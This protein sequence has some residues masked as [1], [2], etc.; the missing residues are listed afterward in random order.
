MRASKQEL[1]PEFVESLGRGLAVLTAFDEHRP[2]LSLSA[3]AEATG[4]ARA[5]ARRALLTLAQLGYV[6]QH[7][8]LFRPTPRVLDLGFARLST[9]TLAQIAQPHLAELVARVHDS[10]SMAVL[11]G[12]DIRYVARVH[13]VRIMSVSITLGT[14][15]PAYA[16]ALGRVL[17]AGLPEAERARRLAALRPQPLTRHTV[18]DTARLAEILAEVDRAG[19]ALVDQELED[20]LRSIAVPVRDR[21]GRVVAAINVSLHAARQSAEASRADLLPAL[22]RTAERVTADLAVASRF[23]RINPA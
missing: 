22:R 14:R 11:A 15:F 3:V 23:A 10:A 20:G 1:G 12:D 4:L 19:Y 13:T 21:A 7:G 16:T 2:A 8:R 18:T 5:T 9:L 17:L 6:T